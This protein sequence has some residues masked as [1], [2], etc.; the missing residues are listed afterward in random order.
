MLAHAVTTCSSSIANCCGCFER[1]IWLFFLFFWLSSLSYSNEARF[2]LFV[3]M[4]GEWRACSWLLCAFCFCPAFVLFNLSH[5]HSFMLGRKNGLM[6]RQQTQLL[7]GGARPLCVSTLPQARGTY[8]LFPSLVF[9]KATRTIFGVLAIFLFSFFF[10][11]FVIFLCLLFFLFCIWV[12]GV[13]MFCLPYPVCV[14]FTWIKPFFSFYPSTSST[15]SV[16]ADSSYKLCETT[17]QL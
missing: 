12:A 5:H 6:W 16:R 4:D 2:F 15:P 1:V 8:F 14:F 3:L 13:R 7:R 11:L 9:P 10:S 17:T